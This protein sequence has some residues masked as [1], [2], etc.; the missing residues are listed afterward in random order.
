MQTPSALTNPML[1]STETVFV[2]EGLIWPESVRIE[3]L[4]YSP[5]W[6]QVTT[7]RQ[8]LETTIAAAGW[9]FFFAVGKLEG[10][11]FGA[12]NP[13]NLRQAMHSILRQVKERHFNA[14]Q[15]TGMKSRKAFGLIRFIAVSAHARHIQRSVQ[16]DNDQQRETAQEQSIWA[17][18]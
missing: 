18:G 15:I 7:D 8:L 6:R 13:V 17:V 16:L 2:Q 1:L 4:A 14:V 10:T 9:H 12:L 3:T 5:G 11:A